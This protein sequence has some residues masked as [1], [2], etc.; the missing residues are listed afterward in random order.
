M[1]FQN[2]NSFE[3]RAKIQTVKVAI[4]PIGAV[5]AHGPHLP[6]GT[7]NYLAERLAERVASKTEAFVLPT[8]P[9][10]QVWS[11]KNFP[12]S[13]N[14][15]NESLVSFLFDMGV[16]LYEQG[17]RVFAVINGHL[18]NAPALKEA[19]RK[20]YSRY[21]DFKVL[22]LFYPGTKRITE[23]VRETKSSHATYFHAC[24]IETSYMLYLAEEYVD[25]SKAITDIPHI[26]LIAD[27]KPTPWE[28]FTNSAVL[29]DATLATKEK[30]EKI[31]EVAIENMVTLIEGA[32]D[33]LNRS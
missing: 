27:V 16:S 3:V 7:D 19:A 21:P 33:E 18:G 11:L 32:K 22:Y 25:M 15:S 17:F 12:G 6:L 1:K 31:I 5:E 14:I 13:I 8:L 2:E 9:Y 23:E 24:E 29:G 30:G 10:G 4:L 20:L 26:P 28:E